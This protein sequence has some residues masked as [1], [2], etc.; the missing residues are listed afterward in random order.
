MHASTVNPT[1][2]VTADAQASLKTPAQHPQWRTHLVFLP[3]LADPVLLQRAVGALGRDLLDDGD[4]LPPFYRRSLLSK[5][6]GR[7]TE[8]T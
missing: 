8:I 4:L 7:L 1:V 6:G 5:G 3:A 2:A